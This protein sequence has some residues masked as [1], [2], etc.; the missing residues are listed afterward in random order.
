VNPRTEFA[1]AY[2]LLR[3]IQHLAQPV[4]AHADIAHEHGSSTGRSTEPQAKCRNFF[5]LRLSR[6]DRCLQM[7]PDPIL[8]P[9]VLRIGFKLPKPAELLSQE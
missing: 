9:E 1:R 6:S 8:L 4:M 5:R 2:F 7:L 3:D